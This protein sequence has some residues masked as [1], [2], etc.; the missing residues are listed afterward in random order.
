M[1]IVVCDLPKV[2]SLKDGSNEYWCLD[3]DTHLHTESH[4]PSGFVSTGRHKFVLVTNNDDSSVPSD[5]CALKFAYDNTFWTYQGNKVVSNGS[6][7]STEKSLYTITHQGSGKVT[8]FDESESK[9]LKLDGHHAKANSA[10]NCGADCLFFVED[11]TPL[12]DSN[13]LPKE[14][15]G[16]IIGVY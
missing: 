4:C 2:F 16:M 8:I 10:T 7:S 6:P 13:E 5:K 3:D 14:T 15:S 9:F 12:A 1:I 11:L